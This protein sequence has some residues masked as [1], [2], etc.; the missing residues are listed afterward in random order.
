MNENEI[1]KQ[2]SKITLCDGTPLGKMGEL[3]LT[4][5]T[6]KFYRQKNF[7][8]KEVNFTI[9][10]NSIISVNA[11]KATI[12]S[13]TDY[14]IIICKDINGQ[15]QT[16]KF[17]HVMFNMESTIGVVYFKSWEDAIQKART[18]KD[19]TRPTSN[20]DELEKLAGLKDKGII[21]EEEFQLKKKQIL[22]I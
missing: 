1:I 14:L 13:N 12:A 18:Q 6:L 20:L 9:P 15:Q 17:Q 2:E 16:L 8:L 19:E 21:T 3:T 10:L 22:G 4:P 11:Q 7:L 5:T